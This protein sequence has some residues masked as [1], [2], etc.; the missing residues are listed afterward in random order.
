[1][2]AETVNDILGY[3]SAAAFTLLASVTL[4]HWFKR[5]DQPSLWAALCFGSL[6]A[7]ALAGQALPEKA[8]SDFELVAQR[9][10]VVV[11]LLFPYLLFKFTTAFEAASRRLEWC[12]AG[13]TAVLIGWT[14]GLPHFAQT[15]EH[16]SLGF[17]IY[18]Y[19]LVAQFG[20]LST[21]SAF[22]LWSAGR[23]QPSVA[24]TRMRMLSLAAVAL[25]VT[26]FFAAATPADEHGLQIATSLL[27]IASALIFLLGFAPPEVVRSLWR[28]PETERVRSAIGDLMTATTPEDVARS[29]LPSM[30]RLVGAR[31]VYLLDDDGEIIAVDGDAQATPPAGQGTF[32]VDIPGGCLVV[33]DGPHAPFFGSDEIE[34]LRSLGALTGLALDRS[35]LFVREHE[36]RIALERAD[37]MKSN[38]IALAAHELRTPVTSIHGVVRTLD[39][40]GEKLSESDRKELE[41]ALH[42]QTERMRGL[43][44]QLLDLSRLEADTV[45]IQPVEIPVRAEVEELVATTAPGREEQIEIRISPKLEATMDRTVFDRVVSNLL[46]NAIRHG[47]AP[48]VV[49]ASQVDNHFRLTVRDN[50]D[51]VPPHFVDD[52]FERFSRSD[53]ARARGTGSGL[54]LAIARSYARAHG[55]DLV[56]EAAQPHG[57]RFELVVPTGRGRNGSPDV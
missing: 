7:V 16:R 47:A 30:I 29:V 34:L 1:V 3:V 24:R 49:A 38:F 31:A 13:L 33:V 12:A 53:E 42:T 46:T 55:G 8:T 9:V 19:A 45:P 36:Q 17:T 32:R 40:L 35:R 41:R 37:E 50:G 44:D 48:V 25:A 22:R 4:A 56:H 5:R 57:A 52:L 39:G 10:L 27:G 54:G 23:D 21:I 11:L 51:G 14:I 20:V 18:I 2:S 15:G 43:V 28:R 6:G 26:L